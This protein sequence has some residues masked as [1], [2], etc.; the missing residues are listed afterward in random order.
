MITEKTLNKYKEYIGKTIG[1]LKVEDIDLS[2]PNRIYF[3]CTCTVCGRKL[4]VRIEQIK[5]I[6]NN[7][8]ESSTTISKES[9]SKV[10]VD[11][12]GEHLYVR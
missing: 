10:I 12:S 9:T 4:K 7:H 1:T 11:G 8:K 3:I 6:Y 5:R 2:I